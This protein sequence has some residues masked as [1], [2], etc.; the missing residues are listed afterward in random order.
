MATSY[1]SGIRTLLPPFD[2]THE[3][4][5]RGAIEQAFLYFLGEGC[6]LTFGEL[7]F[8][9]GYMPYEGTETLEVGPNSEWRGLSRELKAMLTK[10]REEGKIYFTRIGTVALSLCAK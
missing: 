6:A 1:R 9:Q 8:L 10:L 3:L 7:Q 4:L 2:R 5:Q